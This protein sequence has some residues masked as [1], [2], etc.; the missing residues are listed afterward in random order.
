MIL[1]LL[2]AVIAG[3]GATAAA[4]VKPRYTIELA[5]GRTI[6]ALS[7]PEPNAT[8]LLFRRYPDGALMSVRRTL[9]RRVSEAGPATV[10][11]TELKPGEQRELGATGSGARPGARGAIAAPVAAK[12][13]DLLPGE[14]KG[15]TALFNPQRTYRPDWDGKLVPGAT[16]PL[17]NSPNDYKEGATLAHP[18]APAVQAAPGDV[19]RAPN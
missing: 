19:P 17:P 9:V 1:A 7:R 18:A 5:G 4:T 3:T 15:G 16:M 12:S 8:W 14:G 11:G 13:G 2:L 10:S 6:T